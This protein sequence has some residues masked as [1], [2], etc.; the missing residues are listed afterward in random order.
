MINYD[1]QKRMV[2]YTSPDTM[3]PTDKSP[4]HSYDDDNN[5]KNDGVRNSNWKR[6]F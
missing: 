2:I 1:H 3:S 5:G 4:K 6:Q